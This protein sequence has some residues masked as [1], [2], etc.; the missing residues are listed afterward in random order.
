VKTMKMRLLPTLASL[1]VGLAAPAIAQEHTQ[2]GA[3]QSARAQLV[4]TWEENKTIVQ[5]VLCF[6]GTYSV[7]DADHTLNFHIESSTFPNWNGTDQKRAFTVTEDE[8]T[9]T[10]PGSSGGIAHVAWKRAR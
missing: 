8:L 4:G 6:F 1:A 3:A 5:G 10:S 9:Y 2:Q 7:N